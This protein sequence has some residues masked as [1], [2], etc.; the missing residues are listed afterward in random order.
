MTKS[1]YY[2]IVWNNRCKFTKKSSICDG[3]RFFFN[4]FVF[5]KCGRASGCRFAEVMHH[6][7]PK[8]M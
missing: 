7:P 5:V 2:G 4:N 3:W 8:Q 6:C 1:S